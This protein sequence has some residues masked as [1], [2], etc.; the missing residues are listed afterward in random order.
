MRIL[1]LSQFYPPIIGGEERHVRTLSAELHARGHEVAVATLWHDDLPEF[2]VE[3]GV[4]IYRIR[5]LFQRIPGIYSE[6]ERPHAPPLPDPEASLALRRVIKRER[7]EIVHAHNWLIHSFL[8]LKAASRARLAL[9]LH[10]FS[11]VCSR[12]R[13]MYHGKPCTGPGLAKCLRCAHEQYG[14]IKTLPTV[15]GTW[16][17]HLVEQRQVDMFIPVSRAVATGCRLDEDHL[18]YQVIPNLIPNDIEPLPDGDDPRLQ[19]LPAGG[20][21]MFAGDLTEQKG[22]HVLLRAYSE[23]HDAPPLVLIGRSQPDMPAT[24]PPNVTVIESWPHAL[25]MEAWRRST[26]AVVPS[27]CQD[28]CPTVVMEAMACG[29]PVIGARIGGIVDLVEDGQTGL[30]VPPG[31]MDALRH[32]M[33]RLL[34]DGDLRTRFGEAATRRV[35]QFQAS[36]VIPRIEQVYQDLLRRRADQP[37]AVSI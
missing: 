23:L 12:K 16:G 35:V 27:I 17:M 33:G 31:D 37:V 26:I 22:I 34:A 36:S 18:P 13:L 2:E 5:G 24:L 30:I 15:V 8:P 7:P 29:K 14:A 20:Y 10:D 6:R 4:R 25:V 9:T 1:M 21:V 32:A 28:A 11:L 3:S 19:A